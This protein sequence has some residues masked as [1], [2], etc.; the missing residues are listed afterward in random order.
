MQLTWQDNCTHLLCM[1]LLHSSSALLRS[2]M[3]THQHKQTQKQQTNYIYTVCKYIYIYIYERER[4]REREGYI[5]TFARVHPCISMHGKVK[6]S[7]ALVAQ[8]QLFQVLG[9]SNA[10]CLCSDV[11]Q[12]EVGSRQFRRMLSPCGLQFEAA[13]RNVI[14]ASACML[15]W[16]PDVASRPQRT[17]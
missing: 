4:E 13:G 12:V 10:I 17:F 15:M 5:H 9:T 2:S 16:R 3:C 11:L 6:Q 8:K 1:F 14:S 7:Q